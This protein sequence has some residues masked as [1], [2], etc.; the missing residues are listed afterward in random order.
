[1]AWRRF[2][3]SSS[4]GQRAVAVLSTERRQNL[5]RHALELAFLVVSGDPEQDRRRSGVDVSLQA[6]HALR[7][8]AGRH[9]EL[10]PILVVIDRVVAVEK[11]LSL[12]DARSRSSSTL[13]LW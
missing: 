2:R 11:P 12:G 4:G 5:L 13:I 6:V 7:G 8:R 9:P 10:E 3:A 1:M